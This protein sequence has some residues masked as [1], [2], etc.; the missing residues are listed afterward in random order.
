MKP[1][2]IVSKEQDLNLVQDSIAEVIDLISPVCFD[3]S[4]LGPIKLNSG[5]NVFAHK[6]QRKLQGW[7]V[8]RRNNGAVIYDEQTTN[9]FPEISL[10][11]NSSSAVTVWLLIF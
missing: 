10:K 4:L 1:K 7:M 3:L 8:V 6:L 2:R 5:T 9:S 11:L